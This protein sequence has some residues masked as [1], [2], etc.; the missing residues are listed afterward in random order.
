MACDKAFA[1]GHLDDPNHAW[2]EH[3]L[4]SAGESCCEI[5]D[6]H[7]VDDAVEIG[8]CRALPGPARRQ[9]DS[10]SGQG[11]YQS[12]GSADRLCRGL[13]LARRDFVLHARKRQLS[14]IIKNRKSG[15]RSSAKL[16]TRDEA[17]RIAANFAKLRNCRS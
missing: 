15:R 12:E 9:V 3:Q 11:R 13:G 17:R 1:G 2:F 7:R 5:A 4:N 8:R 16:L 6:G 10:G 14:N